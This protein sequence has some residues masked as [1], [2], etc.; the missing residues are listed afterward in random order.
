MPRILPGDL[1]VYYAV[2][3]EGE[4]LLLLHGFGSSTRDWQYQLDDF[5]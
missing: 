4:P 5:S 1:N 2:Y 3:V